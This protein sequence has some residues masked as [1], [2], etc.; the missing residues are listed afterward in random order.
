[1]VETIL[2]GKKKNLPCAVH[3]QSEYDIEGHYI[4][5]QHNNSTYRLR[6]ITIPGGMT[7]GVAKL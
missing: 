5:V 3:L 6:K 2:K 1:M 4:G 7:G